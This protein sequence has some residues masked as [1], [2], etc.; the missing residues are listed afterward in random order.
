MRLPGGLIRGPIRPDRWTALRFA[1]LRWAA[2]PVIDHRWTV[3]LSAIALGFGIFAGVAIGP[4]AEGSLGAQAAQTVIEVV[5]A[6]PQPVI[7]DT[8]PP[9]GSSDG[10][11][12]DRDPAAPS[13]DAS[14]APETTPPEVGP[15]TPITP[16]TPAPPISTPPPQP[17]YSPPPTEP[18]EPAP[19][20]TKVLN[21][22]VVHVNDAAGSYTV[23]SD[24][25][26]LATV[27]SESLPSV[28]NVIEVEAD[29][30]AGGTFTESADRH[31]DGR[32]GQ[33]VLSGTVTYSEPRV[34]GY[35]VSAPGASIFVRVPPLKRMPSLGERVTVQARIAD[36][37]DPI[38]ASPPGRDGCGRP[39][40]L[41][42]RPRTALEQVGLEVTAAPVGT[43]RLEA[44]VQ[45]VCRDARW[46]IVSADDLRESG[47]DVAVAVPAGIEIGGLAP[48]QVVSLD[49]ALRDSGT[50]AAT[51]IAAGDQAKR[52]R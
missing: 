10:S 44:V 51:A 24:S 30:H 4:G 41:P 8:G 35:T 31:A 20:P 1:S 50:Y 14:P 47:R 45:G 29:P 36:Q 18:Q 26:R 42:K 12:P 22:P 34:G 32:A 49:A 2:L 21:G 46:L 39:P 48:G 17:D 23:A 52:A 33:V 5:P 6:E 43:T 38:D 40:A 25:G 16:A 19:D 3:P 28:G 9:S 11:S 37:P 27:L 13:G 15:S 7:A